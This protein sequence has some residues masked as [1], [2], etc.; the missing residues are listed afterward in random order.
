MFGEDRVKSFWLQLGA[1]P[2]DVVLLEYPKLS[3]PG[4]RC[5]LRTMLGQSL[6]APMH[7]GYDVQIT[8]KGLRGRYWIYQW[9][10]DSNLIQVNCDGAIVDREASQVIKFCLHYR[11]PRRNTVSI[12]AILLLDRP[13]DY[14]EVRNRLSRP[15]R[16]FVRFISRRM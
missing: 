15:R 3:T 14:S 5:L 4:F 9:S 16:V 2:K 6:Q 7:W 1:V 8:D 13:A 10:T 12:D 11:E